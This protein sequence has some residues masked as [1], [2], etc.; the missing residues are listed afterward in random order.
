MANGPLTVETRRRLYE[1]DTKWSLKAILRII[2][3]VS[4]FLTTILFAASVS[5]AN[6]NFVDP[7]GQG[8][9]D[10][11]DGMALAPVRPLTS[12]PPTLLHRRY[13][14]LNLYHIPNLI[15]LVSFFIRIF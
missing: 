13:K 2:A 14:D 11:M 5:L 3:T 4:A 8:A 7:Y 15:T 1:E 12:S 9:S 10:W 6:K